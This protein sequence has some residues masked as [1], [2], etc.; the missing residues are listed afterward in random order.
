M[1]L[2][3][4]LCHCAWLGVF[5]NSFLV[6][7]HVLCPKQKRKKVVAHDHHYIASLVFVAST[8]CCQIPPSKGL[9]KL[10]LPCLCLVEALIPK[11][12]TS[13][14]YPI[15][16]LK[17]CMHVFANW[18]FPFT[19]YFF[20]YNQLFKEPASTNEKRKREKKIWQAHGKRA[21]PGPT[22]TDQECKFQ[23]QLS[24]Y[25]CMYFEGSSPTEE[26]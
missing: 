22:L 18:F 10:D 15:Q 24:F 12:T 21:A 3:P 6:K 19:H 5:A 1:E 7:S 26:H 20:L 25:L 2:L 17:S 8:W 16:N 4:A 13:S 11:T 14:K 23:K 9:P